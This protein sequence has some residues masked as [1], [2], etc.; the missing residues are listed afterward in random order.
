MD[1]KFRTAPGKA[2]LKKY[3]LTEEQYLAM[4]RALKWRCAICKRKPKKL[5]LNIDHQHSKEHKEKWVRGLLCF[6]CNKFL[7]GRYK[8]HQAWLFWQAAKYLASKK[9]WRQHGKQKT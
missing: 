3:G 9:D 1:A 6:R 8:R 5:R 7:V 2:T 4:G